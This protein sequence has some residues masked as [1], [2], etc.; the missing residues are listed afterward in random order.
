VFVLPPLP[1]RGERSEGGEAAGERGRKCP[2]KHRLTPT[3]TPS[4]QPSPVKGE[5]AKTNVLR[6]SY[7]NIVEVFTKRR[8]V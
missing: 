2:I 6:K 8:F 5:G 3:S 4:P 1:S 7:Y